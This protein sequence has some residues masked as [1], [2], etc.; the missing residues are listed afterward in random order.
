MATEP[1]KNLRTNEFEETGTQL[2]LGGD[3]H[4]DSTEKDTGKSTALES[5]REEIRLASD[6]GSLKE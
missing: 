4:T 3:P 1:S 6:D 2:E 5:R